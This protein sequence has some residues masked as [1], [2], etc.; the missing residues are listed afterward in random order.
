MAATAQPV[1][2]ITLEP[3]PG[4][5]SQFNGSSADTRCTA[6]PPAPAGL[7]RSSIE[8]FR[9]IDN[10]DFG[11]V[12]FRRTWPALSA[13]R[14]G[15]GRRVLFDANAWKSF[16][17]A[18]LRQ[19]MGEAGALTLFGE[20]AVAHRLFADHITAEYAVKTSGRGRQVEEWKSRP[21]RENH[22]LD[23]LV[24]CAVGASILGVTVAG[25]PPEKPRVRRRVSLREMQE[26]AR[27]GR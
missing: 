18:R 26:R 16:V 14:R 2:I 17:A 27:A 22:W 10:R 3:Q 7:G 5:Q 13:P 11:T 12:I 1:E 15:E 9:H 21:N 6:A 4:P 25:V 23:A 20:E 19:P 8:P 24:G